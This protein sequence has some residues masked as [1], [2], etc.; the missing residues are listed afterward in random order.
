MN[1]PWGDFANRPGSLLAGLTNLLPSGT[2]TTN[3]AGN[4]ALALDLQTYTRFEG[5]PGDHIDVDFGSAVELGALG[6]VDPVGTVALHHSDDGATY[7]PVLSGL[8]AARVL[9][10]PF[11][12]SAHRYWRIGFSGAGAGCA[13]AWLGTIHYGPG[14]RAGFT[15]PEFA[16]MVDPLVNL[17]VTGQVL[18]NRVQANVSRFTLSGAPL[19]RALVESV[20]VPL[21]NYAKSGLPFFLKWTA[22]KP[23]AFCW[24]ASTPA[25]IGLTDPLFHNGSLDLNG[26]VEGVTQ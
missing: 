17:S 26:W 15:P 12:P 13:V 1:A 8:T 21:R 16:D 7:T 11:T 19:D 23:A 20:W 14:Q 10:E 2:V 6:L 24:Q 5:V 18:G 9:F 4:P 22:S 25:A 3:G